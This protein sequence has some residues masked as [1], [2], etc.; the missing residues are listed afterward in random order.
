[1]SRRGRV[2][3]AGD[4]PASASV[5]KLQNTAKF[6]DSL[7]F[8]R[9]D[10]LATDAMNLLAERRCAFLPAAR[11]YPRRASLRQ[12]LSRLRPKILITAIGPWRAVL[13]GP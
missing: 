3:H 10:L 12:N 5:K 9:C 1:M 2:K 13:P 11:R 6:V 8:F 7:G 4:V